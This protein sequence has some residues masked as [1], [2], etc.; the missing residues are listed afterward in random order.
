V[1]IVVA[2][3]S[4][5]GSVSA[6]EAAQ[7]IAR[8][9]RQ[10]LPDV[11]VELVPMADGGEGTVQ[12]LVDAT[13][14]QIVRATVTGP[15]GTP[16]PAFFGLLG[17]G[18][19]AVIEMAAASGLPLVPP[20]QRN[21][22]I[23]TTRGTGDLIRAALDAGACKLI[24]GIGGSATVDGGAG[25]AQALGARLTDGGGQEIGPG[26]GELRRLAH[27]DVSNLDPRLAEVEV[28]VAC[29]VT[30]PLTGPRGAARVYG[31]QK[32]ATPTMVEIL[33]DA[34]VHYAAVIAA[35]LGVA[36][37][38]VPGA[39]AAGGLG[40]G[41]MAF[42][43]AQLRPGVEI[44]LEAT[45]LRERIRG[46][47]LVI[48]GEGQMDG[49]TVFGKTPIGVARAA[50]A[51]GVPV[52]AL[53]GGTGDDYDAVYA[54]GMDAVLSIPVRPMSLGDAMSNAPALL[55]EAGARAMRLLRLGQRLT[56]ES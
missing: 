19:T 8:G 28:V 2:P 10:V 42:L 3:D 36:V 41:L 45:R 53:V 7:A 25:M 37:R 33:D 50:Q 5:K 52:L 48:T 26:G 44:V 23:T 40:A 30:N 32:G 35:D 21:P 54:Y 38:D 39:G 29:D 51:E 4:F 1:R 15:L 49:Q 46:A 56:H 14:G 9:V 43:H 34:L 55:A 17:D 20:H 16:V 18:Q 47:D 13:G 31:P 22:L 27:V 11:Q 24:V 6:L 12:S